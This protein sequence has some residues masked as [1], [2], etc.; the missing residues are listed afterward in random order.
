VDG[1]GRVV[2]EAHDTR[3]LMTRIGQATPQMLEAY[4]DRDEFSAW[5]MRRGHPKLSDQL[6]PVY[7]KGEELRQN[8][9]RILGDWLGG[10]GG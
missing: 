1:D 8:L 9:M 7:G 6:R 5:L 2:A 4:S 10:D 3:E